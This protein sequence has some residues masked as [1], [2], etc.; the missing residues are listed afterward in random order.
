[1][2]YGLSNGHATDDVTWPRR[3]DEAVRSAVL[4]TAWL[5]VLG[6]SSPRTNRRHHCLVIWHWFE[7]CKCIPVSCASVKCRQT[8]VLQRLA[9]AISNI[10]IK[11]RNLYNWS[12]KTRANNWR[13][14]R[15]RQTNTSHEST[16]KT[17]TKLLIG[18][19]LDVFTCTLAAFIQW[20][21]NKVNI[22]RA[23]PVR[24]P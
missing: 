16:Q 20:R 11:A 7:L 18:D 14:T 10:T 4:A 24:S 22:A 23:R 2:V 3:C 5:L 6:C 17:Q 12:Q 13:A 19:R 15:R 21:R 8:L 1:M 9:I